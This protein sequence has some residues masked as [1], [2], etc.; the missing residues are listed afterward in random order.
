[1]HRTLWKLCSCLPI[2]AASP[3]WAGEE[4]P[5]C[6]N[7]IVEEGEECDDGNAED[8]DGCLSD[9]TLVDLECPV[10]GQ[11]RRCDRDKAL[12]CHIP[13]G[14]PGNAH[15]ICVGQPAVPAHLAHGDVAGACEAECPCPD[16]SEEVRECDPDHKVLVCHIPPGNPGNAHTICVDHHAQP[17]HVENHGDYLGACRNECPGL[18]GW[19]FL[20][21]RAG[22]ESS[23]GGEA[24]GCAAAWS[25]PVAFALAFLTLWLWG[26]RRQ[27]AR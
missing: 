3:A 12:V 1:M 16:P 19:Y 14:N 7:G 20:T 10:S 17:A 27:R 9:C 8:S 25:G 11:P 23:G 13:P 21:A 24:A 26:I 15:S 2:I 22:G 6:G 5:C 4:G 18:N